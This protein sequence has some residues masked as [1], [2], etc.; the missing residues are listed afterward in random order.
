MAPTFPRV[1][2]PGVGCTDLPPDSLNHAELLHEDASESLHF[3][4]PGVFSYGDGY[5]FR[6]R[7]ESGVGSLSHISSMAS[8]SVRG[9]F[10]SLLGSTVGLQDCKV[11]ELRLPVWRRPMHDPTMIITSDKGVSPIDIWIPISQLASDTLLNSDQDIVVHV[12]VDHATFTIEKKLGALK[13]VSVASP[14]N[15]SYGQVQVRTRPTQRRGAVS[16]GQ[17]LVNRAL[18]RNTLI[19]NEAHASL[20]ASTVSPGNEE[21]EDPQNAAPK[22]VE[23]TSL[24]DCSGGLSAAGM[25]TIR[26]AAM[27]VFGVPYDAVS[28]WTANPVVPLLS[29]ED[30]DGS[31]PSD[32]WCFEANAKGAHLKLYSTNPMQIKAEV[33]LM[34]NQTYF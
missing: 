29:K 17:L 31:Y 18:N 32:V 25:D 23:A 30:V 16:F 3:F 5:L 19:V 9:I 33:V 28:S 10:A 6:V 11:V 14:E 20:V 22:S 8:G 13:V 27:D 24:V 21:N 7:K 1:L 12:Q 26:N 4:P 2:L 15:I 34:C